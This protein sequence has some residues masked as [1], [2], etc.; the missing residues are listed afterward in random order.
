MARYVQ[1]MIKTW[2]S[3]ECTKFSTVVTEVCQLDL[4]LD[5]PR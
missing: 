4:D 2:I 5:D 1:G 3:G